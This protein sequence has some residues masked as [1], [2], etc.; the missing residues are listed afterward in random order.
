[1]PFSVF[2]GCFDQGRMADL[3][4]SLI[5]SD[6]E[7]FQSPADSAERPNFGFAFNI[8]MLSDE[9]ASRHGELAVGHLCLTLDSM[10]LIYWFSTLLNMLYDP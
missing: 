1:M 9:T 3:D 2:Q 4:H 8:V 7:L 10:M 5:R 6:L